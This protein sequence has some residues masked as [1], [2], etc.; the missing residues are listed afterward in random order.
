MISKH[1]PN[2]SNEKLDNFENVGYNTLPIA[3]LVQRQRNSNSFS[4]MVET[5]YT[6]NKLPPANKIFGPPS[7]LIEKL[8]PEGEQNNVAP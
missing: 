1:T 5:N 2:N 8:L 3:R 6:Y 7:P 4:L